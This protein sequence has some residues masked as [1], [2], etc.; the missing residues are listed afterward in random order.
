MNIIKCCIA[1]A[2][3]SQNSYEVFQFTKS[4]RGKESH[5]RHQLVEQ[6]L[7]TA[8]QFCGDKYLLKLVAEAPA[9]TAPY[10]TTARSVH[11]ALKSP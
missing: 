2:A 3:L 8:A 5:A 10:N 11:P 9:L 6:F 4:E 7:L 1:S